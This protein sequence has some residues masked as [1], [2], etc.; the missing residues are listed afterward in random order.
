M[1][2]FGRLRSYDPFLIPVHALVWTASVSWRVAIFSQL[3]TRRSRYLYTWVIPKASGERRGGLVWPATGVQNSS[4]LGASVTFTMP[5]TFSFQE[6][7]DM[8]YVYGFCDVISVLAV[9]EISNAFRIVEYQTGECLL[10]FTRHC[11]IPVDFPAFVLQPSVVLMQASMKKVLFLWYTA[12]HVRV[13]EKLQD[14]F[15][16]PTRECAEHCM[17]SRC[18]HTTCSECNISDL[19]ILLSGW[20]FA[21]G[22][23]TVASCI[24]TSCLQTKRNLIATVSLIQPILM[25][26][27]MRI[28]TP[29]LKATFNNVSVS[30]CGV[31]SSGRSA[32]RAFHLGRSS[33]RRGVPRI[34][35]GGIAQTFGGCAFG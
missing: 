19:A 20:T 4:H 9:P 24:V 5:F 1:S 7:A 25:C 23:I 8:I 26:G 35:T 33:Y 6:Y 30:M 31:C 22:S 34:S 12:V 17:Q 32:D 13:R 29:L 10:E 2:D 14:I 15:M 21:S 27:E 11:E 16:F 3:Q 28:P 18:I